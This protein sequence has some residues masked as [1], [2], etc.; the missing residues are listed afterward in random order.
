MK[1]ALID[2][3]ANAVEKLIYTKSTR[4]TQGFDTRTKIHQMSESKK[5]AELEYMANTIPSSWEFVNYTFEIQG[6][7]R[8]FTHQFVRTRTGSY[9]QQT[10]RMLEMEKFKYLT[11]ETIVEGDKANDIYMNCMIE[12]QRAYD[13]LLELGIP[14][15]DARGVLPTNILTNIIAQFNLRT[16]AEMAKSRTGM[17]TQ[18]EYRD[19]FDAMAEAVLQVHPWAEMFLFP[20]GRNCAKEIEGVLKRVHDS[21]IIN[22]EEYIQQ[23]KNV[24]KLK[25]ES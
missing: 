19:V 11:P 9:A 25:K 18:S 2:Y 23:L 1:V 22:K 12:I 3:T 5:L 20:K 8:A 21:G 7:T 17:R 15:E 24:D 13:N 6:V 14:A 4:L 16:I 10:M